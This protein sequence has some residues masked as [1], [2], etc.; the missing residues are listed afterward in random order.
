MPEPF[1]KEVR[2]P[3]WEPVAVGTVMPDCA[4]PDGAMEFAQHRGPYDTWYVESVKKTV[5]AAQMKSRCVREFWFCKFC[6]STRWFDVLIDLK[7]GD[8]P[9]EEREAW[10]RRLS[11]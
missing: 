5:T 6:N 7:I 9:P 10:R 4:S 8:L 2:C 11:T 3:V 1:M